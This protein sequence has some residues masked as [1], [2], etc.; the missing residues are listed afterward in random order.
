[1]EKEHAY[2]RILAADADIQYH[3]ASILEAKANDLA[4]AGEW[5]IQHIHRS[6]EHNHPG[7]LKEAMGIHEQMIEIIEGITKVETG[8][9]RHIKMVLSED[10]SSAQSASDTDLSKMFDI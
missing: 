5:T 10:E 9:A 4:K 7:Q 1:M 8:L 2:V 6:S 3:L